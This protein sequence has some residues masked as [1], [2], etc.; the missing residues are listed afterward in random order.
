MHN[1]KEINQAVILSTPS[2]HKASVA[3]WPPNSSDSDK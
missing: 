3:Y 2:P 1:Q